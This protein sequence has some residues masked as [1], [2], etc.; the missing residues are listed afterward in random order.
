[1]SDKRT[2]EEAKEIVKKLQKGFDHLRHELGE[3][4]R[5]DFSFAGW[6]VHCKL[7]QKYYRICD[8]SDL[9]RPS[10]A[11]NNMIKWPGSAYWGDNF[12]GNIC[13]GAEY[14]DKELREQS[15]LYAQ[16]RPY[17]EDMCEMDVEEK[18]MV[19]LKAWYNKLPYV[20]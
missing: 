9:S 2:E 5:E 12:E 8:S 16:L 13:F 7:C 6:E 1:M 19:L 14:R 15:V 3:P 4:K 10:D 11:L 18:L 17:A 20:G